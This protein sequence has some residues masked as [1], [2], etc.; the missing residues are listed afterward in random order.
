MSFFDV[1]Q[2]PPPPPTPE[3]E[4]PEWDGPPDGVLPGVSTQRPVLFHTDE[5]HFMVDRILVYPNGLEV[6]LALQM[7]RPEEF[8]AGPWDPFGVHPTTQ[9]PGDFIRIGLL[10]SDGTKWT[11]LNPDHFHYPHARH[12]R[13]PVILHRSSGGGGSR[14]HMKYWV[15]PMPPEGPLE[16]FFS[17]P[18]H[19]VDEASITIDVTE[20]H[21]RATEAVPLWPG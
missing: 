8:Q 19:G 9:H 7:R 21:E 6:A 10:L 2:P 18:A 4:R 16:V 17:W 15:W 5:A 11:N 13:P 14:W 12:P 1:P 3:R 20:L